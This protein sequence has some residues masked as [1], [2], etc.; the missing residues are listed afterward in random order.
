M[1]PALVSY[2]GFNIMG[3]LSLL[4]VLLLTPGGVGKGVF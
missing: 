4:M 3:G 1:C 2:L